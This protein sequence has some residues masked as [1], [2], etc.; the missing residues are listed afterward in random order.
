[1]RVMFCPAASTG[2]LMV[3]V[4]VRLLTPVLPPLVPA[5]TPMVNVAL[6]TTATWPVAITETF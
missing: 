1:M 5:G 3:C 4:P 6:A 2:A